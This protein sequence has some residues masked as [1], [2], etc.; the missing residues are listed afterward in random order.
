MAG[1]QSRRNKQRSAFGCMVS[2]EKTKLFHL[3][4]KA[5]LHNRLDRM[6]HLSKEQSL[7]AK[8]LQLKWKMENYLKEP[9]YDNQNHF[10]QFLET[11][12]DALYSKRNDFAR[13]IKT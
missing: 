6:K 8:L 3:D 1:H 9:D 4:Q 11:Y 7:R 2:D 13:D 12:V 10:S 5:Q